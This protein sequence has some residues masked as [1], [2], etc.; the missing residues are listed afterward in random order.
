[1]QILRLSV[2]FLQRKSILHLTLKH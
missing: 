2:A 1:L